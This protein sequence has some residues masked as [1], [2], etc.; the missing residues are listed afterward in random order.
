MFSSNIY[1][2][3]NRPLDAVNDNQINLDVR[4]RARINLSLIKSIIT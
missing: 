1:S 4:D 2:S 3:M